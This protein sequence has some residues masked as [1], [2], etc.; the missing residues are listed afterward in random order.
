VAAG[1]GRKE[2]FV[3]CEDGTFLL[4]RESDGEE[5]SKVR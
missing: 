3:R 1:E 5:R 4:T 2:K